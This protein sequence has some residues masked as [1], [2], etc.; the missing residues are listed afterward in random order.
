VLNT[1]LTELG[2]R[3]DFV[4]TGDAAVETTR[5]GRYDIILMDVTLPGIDGL[6]AARRIR[7]LGP[8]AGATPIVGISG[9]S[10]AGDEAAGR[11]AGMDDYLIK[12]LSPSTL[13]PILTSL[14][15][16]G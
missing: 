9:R 1:I 13:A 6:E 11:A 12:P 3:A 7:A 4:G 15:S 8:P 5:R 2:H 16:R 14:T 10:H